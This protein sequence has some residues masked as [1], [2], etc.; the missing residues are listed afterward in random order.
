VPGDRPDRFD[1]AISCGTDITI[2]D[3]E[4][5]VAPDAKAGA[6][7]ALESWLDDAH[8]VVVRVNEA[9]SPWFEEDLQLCRRP[10]VLGVM[11]PKASCGALN[12][13]VFGKREVI[14]LVET[15]VGIAEVDAIAA[16]DAVARMA[17]GTIDLA[18]DLG[19]T[20]PELVTP[21]LGMRLVIAS[22][23]AHKPAPIA[24]V[25]PAIDDEDVLHA[26]LSQSNAMGFSGKMCV[27]PRQV[28]AIHR[29][30]RPPQEEILR[31]RAIVK[32]FAQSGGA[33]VKLD[34]AMIDKP[35]VDRALR[36]LATAAAQQ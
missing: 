5:A 34:G 3:L 9:G 19:M 7:A 30:L 13:T 28:A 2:V 15:A 21:Q 4:D 33:A 16:H 8:P 29:F 1:K 36:L 22:R 32:A 23:L 17:L 18:L 6:R 14:A 12:A 25:S 31:A 35:I 26:H 20:A 11:L 24:G 27:H 10:G